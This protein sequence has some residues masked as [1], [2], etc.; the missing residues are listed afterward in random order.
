MTETDLLYYGDCLD[1]L[2]R[3][4][5]DESVD[6]TYLDP[7]FQSSRNWNV[8]MKDESGRE[9]DAEILAFEDTWHWGPTSE[10]TYAYLV[11][12]RRNEGRVPEQVSRI[13]GALHA[14]L[15]ANQMTA[16]L[17]MMTVRLLELHRVLKPTGSLFLHCDP[18]ASHYLKTILDP[19]FGTSNF[20]NE[21][22]WKRSDAHNDSGGQGAKH[23]GRLHD[24][25]L[26][27]RKSEA[28]T[29]ND[30]Y[31]PLPQSTIDKWYRHV[32]PE[33]GRRYNLA[34][35]AGPGGA[36]KGNPQYEFLGVT[37]YWRYSKERMQ[38][39][40][41]E[42]LIV[43]SRPGAVP[44]RKRYLD[45][46]KGVGLQDVWTDI[47]MLRGVTKG[48]RQGYPTEKPVALLER[49]IEL[50][51]NEGDVVLDPFCGCGT[52]LIASQKLKRRWIG[53]DITFLSI[54]V[55]RARLKDTFGLEDVRVLGQPTEVEGARELA[56]SSEGRYQFQWWALN[57]VEAKPV[58]GVEKKGRDRGIDGVITFLDEKQA[59][60]TIVVSVK[61]GQVNSGMVR[62]LK[63]T[64]EREAASIGFFV[65]LEEATKEMNL[66]AATAGLY[67]SDLWNRDYPKL[68]I[69][70][71]RQ[72][73][74]GVKPELP[75]SVQPTY[76]QARRYQHPTGEQQG[77]FAGPP[78]EE[79]S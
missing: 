7:P 64:V 29:F 13:V 47:E 28:A 30:L 16:Y 10:T 34:D 39:L 40:Y 51:S 76:A 36:A 66:E 60:Q 26:F 31:N 72:L 38:E 73:L 48:A 2:R 33:T 41:D 20:V 18:T 54:A 75:P 78:G 44:A 68:Q 79:P 21:I 5:P 58:G 3:Y 12:S 19:I 23:L 50:G 52:A 71:I 6:L 57:L 49:I 53:I 59:I 24:V 27:Y 32:E 65:T 35:I 4:M 62:D 17:V 25:I 22:I 46:S 11:D 1:I 43:Q 74:A 37:R 15:G 42:G 63:G 14:A 56:Q 69:L 8:I 55:M 45:E 61:S 70:S 9:S 77:L 67:H